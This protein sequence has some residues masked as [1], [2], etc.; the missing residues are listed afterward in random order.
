MSRHATSFVLGYHG[1]LR[2]T[3]DDVVA[4]RTEL[5]H[6]D[7]DYDWLGAGAYF[8]ESDVQRAQEWA[9]HRFGADGAVIGA[10]IDLRNCLDLVSRFDLELVREAHPRFLKFC[11]DTGTEAPVNSNVRNDPNGDVLLRRLDCAVINFLNRSMDA[12]PDI[13]SFDT[14]RG[15]FL[16]GGPLYEGSAIREKN[17]VQIAVRNNDVIKGF[18]FPRQPA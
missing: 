4:G 10:V 5:A 18:F 8:W 14:V 6:S 17:H 3:A 11:T 13:E 12:S 15:M 7:R 16:E 9:Q 1:C 2:S